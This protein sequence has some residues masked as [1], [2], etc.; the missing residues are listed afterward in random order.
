M[1][2][3][4]LALSFGSAAEAYERGRPGWPAA[5]LD[6]LPLAPGAA[7]L[8]LAAGTGKLTR[9]LAE[10]FGVIAVEPDPAM[11]R[12]LSRVTGC[13]EAL[14]GTAEAIPLEAEAVDGVLVAEA[15][16]WFD[17][18]A[19][20]AEIA[21]VLRPRG[22]L[23]LLWN[24]WNPEDYVLP[25]GVVD[26]GGSPKHALLA[27]DG[28]RAAFEGAPYEPLRHV[29]LP[30]ERD[31]PRSELLDYFASISPIASL[32]EGPRRATLDRIAGALD[33]SAYRR[34]WTTHLHWTRLAG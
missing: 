6:A 11:R 3:D 25:D 7:V 16:H 13:R 23:A 34:R 2:A 29:E 12:V 9:L 31:V 4:E 14:E 28:W 15:F 5:A 21:R 19:A 1:S 30:Q 17:G 8:D 33:R 18:R 27:D 24:R 22:V 10:R 20:L 26:W 32:P